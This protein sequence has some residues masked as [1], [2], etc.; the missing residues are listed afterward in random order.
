MLSR[1]RT[2]SRQVGHLHDT[3]ADAYLFDPSTGPQ[4]RTPTVRPN[5]ERCLS[6]VRSTR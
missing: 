2:V 6:V 5:P 3:S 4:D 1:I